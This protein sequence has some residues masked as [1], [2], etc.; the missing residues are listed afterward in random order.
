[1][2]TIQCSVS[3]ETYAE[4]ERQGLLESGKLREFFEAHFNPE[5]AARESMLAATERLYGRKTTCA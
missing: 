3:D 4:L 2:K 1:M 5:T